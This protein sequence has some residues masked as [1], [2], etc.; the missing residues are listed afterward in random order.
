[1]NIKKLAG[2]SLACSAIALA[3]A[4]A[5]AGLWLELYDGASTVTIADGQTGIV[6]DANAAPNVVTWIGSLGTWFVNVST[7]LSFAPS[8]EA[9]IDLSS[10]DVSAGSGT[11]RLTMWTDA[12]DFTSPIGATTVH[13][14]IGGTT[15]GKV[16][17]DAYLDDGWVNSIGPLPGPAFSGSTNTNVTTSGAFDL[18]Q[19]VKITHTHA[20][21]SSFDSSVSVPEPAI[22]G[23]LG[24][25]LLGFG[26]AR[27]R[28]AA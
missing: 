15:V 4:P 16:G 20:G 8:G 25:G 26:F 17:V 9:G 6:A 10:V 28:L 12:L 3:A 18:A 19:V 27:R 21:T 1:M 13:T 11:L 24:L 22:L 7:A 2:I 5:Q 23:L 14:S